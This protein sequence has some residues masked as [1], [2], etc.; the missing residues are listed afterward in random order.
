MPHKFM[1]FGRAAAALLCGVALAGPLAA[2]QPEL[3]TPD[4]VIKSLYRVISGPA[5]QKREWDRLRALFLP[6]AKMIGVR[7]TADTTAPPTLRIMEVEDY[8]RLSGPVIEK[9][10][11][12]EGEIARQLD[13]YGLEAH[14]FSTYE[15]RH[16]PADATPITRG[17]NSIQM[18]QQQGRWWIVS[19]TWDSETGGQ[20]PLPARFLP[21]SPTAK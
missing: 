12:Y 1:V 7:R 17:I 11:F 10:G 2:Q 8:I 6:G 13:V 21:A 5:G 9:S 4:G 19:I 20:N 3:T 18:V 14:A 15:T 16:T